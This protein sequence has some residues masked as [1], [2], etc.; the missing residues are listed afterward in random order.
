MSM[1]RYNWL[2]RL[3]YRV[4][5]GEN[6]RDPDVGNRWTELV[7]TNGKKL[8]RVKINGSTTWRGYQ[9]IEEVLEDR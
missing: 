3:G 7:M 6:W 4:V 9:T 1:L 5:D 2:R 8:K